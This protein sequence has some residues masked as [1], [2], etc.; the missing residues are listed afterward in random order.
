MTGTG[1]SHVISY[2]HKVRAGSLYED[3]MAVY[4]MGL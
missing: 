3:R 4:R 2:L 1:V